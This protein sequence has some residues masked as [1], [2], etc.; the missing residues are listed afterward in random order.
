L[1]KALRVAFQIVPN[2]L[3]GH[4]AILEIETYIKQQWQA[5]ERTVIVESRR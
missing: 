1:G 4:G 2:L 5:H 3:S